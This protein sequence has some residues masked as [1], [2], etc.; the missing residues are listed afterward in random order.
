MSTSTDTLIGKRFRHAIA[1]GNPLFEVTRRIGRS[2]RYD[3]VCIDEPYEI[4]GRKYPSDFAGEVRAF[5]GD[6][7][8]RAVAWQETIAN[9]GR[10]Q[11]DFWANRALGEELHY[12]DSF[13]RYVRGKVVILTPENTEERTNARAALGQRGLLPTALVGDWQPR[14]LAYRDAEGNVKYGYHAEKIIA[15]NGAW[16]PS[17][18]CV[19]EGSHRPRKGE[20]PRTM[21]PLSLDP[22]PARTG[23]DAHVE[24]LVRAR[25]QVARR[26][27]ETY[28]LAD[29]DALEAHLRRLAR[30][31]LEDLDAAD[32]EV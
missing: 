11:D 6:Q 4:G 22:P 13:G 28:R 16:Q 15:G 29:G 24:R 8:R 3:A 26:V 9:L 31:L 7:V 20:D 1:D 12:H 27:E 30:F 21:R 10:T 14:D 19:F 32:K 23:A 5:T 18:T 2:D 17:E 25:N